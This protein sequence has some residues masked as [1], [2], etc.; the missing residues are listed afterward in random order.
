MYNLRRQRRLFALFATKLLDLELGGEIFARATE[1]KKTLQE[2]DNDIARGLI[3]DRD[4]ISTSAVVL[5]YILVPTRDANLRH[6]FQAAVATDGDATYV[7]TNYRQLG[8]KSAIVGLNDR[9]C[10]RTDLMEINSDELVRRGNFGQLVEQINGNCRGKG[11][12]VFL[13]KMQAF[14]IILWAII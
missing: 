9:L 2:I 5:T 6:T 10:K 4:F 8:I 14:K 1:N 13:R 3:K 12:A 11:R 7:L